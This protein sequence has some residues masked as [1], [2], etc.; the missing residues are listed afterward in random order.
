MQTYTE[1][2][3]HQAAAIYTYENFKETSM[4][5][6]TICVMIILN[7]KQFPGLSVSYLQSSTQILNM[8]EIS[9]VISHGC[10]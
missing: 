5:L 10:F 1:A 3:Y 8:M 2:I 4:V 9:A 6:F 7:P